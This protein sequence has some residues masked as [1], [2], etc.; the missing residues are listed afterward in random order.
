MNSD[1]EL[2]IDSTL[3]IGIAKPEGASMEVAHK[4]I[5]V[6]TDPGHVPLIKRKGKGG[7]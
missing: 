6:K 3:Q 5:Y 1:T 2:S 4:K 7:K